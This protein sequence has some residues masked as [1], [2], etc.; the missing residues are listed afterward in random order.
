MYSRRMRHVR[1]WRFVNGGSD[2]SASK[3]RPMMTPIGSLYL[4]KYGRNS[5]SSTSP[6]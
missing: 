2:S 6:R 5:L 1:P 3:N 4:V